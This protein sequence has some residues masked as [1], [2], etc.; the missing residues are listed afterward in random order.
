MGS[1]VGKW[2]GNGWDIM[3]GSTYLASA[4]CTGRKTML[5]FLFGGG[6]SMNNEAF[7]PLAH[8][9]IAISEADQAMH[10]SE[11]WDAAVDVKHTLCM[12]Q[13]IAEAVSPLL[14]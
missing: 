12:K 5:V 7:R 3:L 9:I 10:K 14:N 4:W 13:I 1:P 2:V 11:E 8:E 6:V